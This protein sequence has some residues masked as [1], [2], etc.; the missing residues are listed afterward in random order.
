MRT[1]LGPPRGR[2]RVFTGLFSSGSNKIL[3]RFPESSSILSTVGVSK[4]DQYLC[5][6]PARMIALAAIDIGFFLLLSSSSSIL[7][8]GVP[9]VLILKNELSAL[10]A[11][12]ST[13]WIGKLLVISV[14]TR[15]R[16]DASKSA[17]SDLA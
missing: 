6:R 15:V 13:H 10:F 12:P 14:L 1:P 11:S 5:P 3:W 16:S 9:F 2:S 8:S 4:D 7:S 17:A